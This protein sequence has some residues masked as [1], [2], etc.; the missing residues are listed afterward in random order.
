[1][2]NEVGD[3]GPLVTDVLGSNRGVP[4]QRVIDNANDDHGDC[5]NQAKHV[6][7]L[8]FRLSLKKPQAAEENDKP[9]KYRAVN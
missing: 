7:S 8:G 3:S 1:M 2:N 5:R 6:L 9:G 4:K